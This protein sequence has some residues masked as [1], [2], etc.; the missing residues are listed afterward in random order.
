MSPQAGDQG[1][2]VALFQSE[3]QQA[4]KRQ[5]FS[6]SQKQDRADV[7]VSRQS[8]RRNFLLLRGGSPFVIFRPSTD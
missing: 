8:G 5:C 1:E 3:G 4:R 2:P 7:L 6:L